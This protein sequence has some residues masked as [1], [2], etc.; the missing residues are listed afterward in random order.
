MSAATPQPTPS[1]RRTRSQTAAVDAADALSS[2]SESESESLSSITSSDVAATVIQGPVGTN[3][4]TQEHQDLVI[5]KVIYASAADVIALINEATSGQKLYKVIKVFQVIK[6][7]IE[8]PV[9]SNHNWQ[10]WIR[11]VQ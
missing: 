1:T 5:G 6:D 2:I 9:L 4:N 8:I 7:S 3:T 11:M 10:E